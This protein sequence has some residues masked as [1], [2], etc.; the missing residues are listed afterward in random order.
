MIKSLAPNSRD[1]SRMARAVAAW[2]LAVYWRVRLRYR[3]LKLR[4]LMWVLRRLTGGLGSDG[5]GRSS[6]ECHMKAPGLEVSGSDQ[7]LT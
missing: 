1:M 6:D 5:R 7:G 4:A 3:V 2:A